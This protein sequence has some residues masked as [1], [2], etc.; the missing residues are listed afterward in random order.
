MFGGF[1]YFLLSCIVNRFKINFSF[2]ISGRL[3]L[4]KLPPPIS[5]YELHAC[6][7]RYFCRSRYRFVQKALL[8]KKITCMNWNLLN[9]GNR[10]LKILYGIVHFFGIMYCVF[11]FVGIV[12]FTEIRFGNYWNAKPC[13]VQYKIMAGGPNVIYWTLLE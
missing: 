12:R 3:S 4:L 11:L 7:S 13:R 2:Q 8:K 9:V 1:L 10:H 5:V 6:Q